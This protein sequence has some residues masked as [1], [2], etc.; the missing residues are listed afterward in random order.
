MDRKHLRKP[1]MRDYPE[2][3]NVKVP[4]DADIAVSLGIENLRVGRHYLRDE[5]RAR[6][7][8]LWL[9]T[10]WILRV[11][12]SFDHHGL[13]GVAAAHGEK[14]R[15]KTSSGWMKGFLASNGSIAFQELETDPLPHVVARLPLLQKSKSMFLDGVGYQLR[16]ESLQIKSTLDFANPTLP[17]LVAVETTCWEL[18]DKI[19][20]ESGEKSLTAFT[21]TWQRYHERGG[22]TMP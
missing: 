10:F 3:P 2:H 12:P 16:I 6:V 4:D 13:V 21:K 19:A 22:I 8:A 14:F 11:L 1:L 9:D 7:G 20:R 18:A 17:E 15:G 5:D